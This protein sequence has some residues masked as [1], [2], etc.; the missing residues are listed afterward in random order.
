MMGRLTS[1]QGGPSARDVVLGGCTRWWSWRPQ[2]ART[3]TTR[4]TAQRRRRMH[5]SRR[6]ARRA[7]ISTGGDH[8][9]RT[10]SRTVRGECP[11]G[12]NA[13]V[14]DNYLVWDGTYTAEQCIAAIPRQMRFLAGAKVALTPA[15]D[16]LVYSPT[17]SAKSLDG[18]PRGRLYTAGFDVIFSNPATG[19][20]TPPIRVAA[21]RGRPTGRVREVHRTLRLNDASGSEAERRPMAGEQ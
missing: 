15:V 4:P 8:R 13:A 21:R 17:Q 16:T 11:E 20:S 1:T 19:A 18:S 14:A 12:R 5:R 6:S 7:S 9:S 10:M 2:D 3:T